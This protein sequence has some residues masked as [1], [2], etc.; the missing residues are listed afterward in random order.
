MSKTKQKNSRYCKAVSYSVSSSA[1]LEELT[2]HH[3]PSVPHKLKIKAM[4][5]IYTS[6]NLQSSVVMIHFDWWTLFNLFLWHKPVQPLLGHSSSPLSTQT[7][8]FNYW[9]QSDRLFIRQ[10]ASVSGHFP[11][12]CWKNKVVTYMHDRRTGELFHYVNSL[13]MAKL[14]WWHNQI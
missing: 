5:H 6:V 11:T 2:L 4:F 8:D 7:C 1:M 9:E 12:I 3:K 10:H 13:I 14:L